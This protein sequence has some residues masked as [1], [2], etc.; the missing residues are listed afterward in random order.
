MNRPLQTLHRLLLAQLLLLLLLPFVGGCYPR[1]TPLQADSVALRVVSYALQRALRLR[2]LSLRVADSASCTEGPALA[3]S[4]A[5]ASAQELQIAR[6]RTALSY[7]A[8]GGAPPLLLTPPTPPFLSPEAGLRALLRVA[9]QGLQA[10][11]APLRA[12]ENRYLLRLLSRH[13]ASDNRICALLEQLLGGSA[14]T[15]PRHY[16]LCPRCGYLGSD[17]YPDPACPQCLLSASHFL[18]F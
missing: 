5:I 13:A 8:A 2:D 3:L 9:D 17:R 11:F 10:P 1:F 12:G 6:Y 14:A 15:S 16:L 7:Y 4:R 18:R